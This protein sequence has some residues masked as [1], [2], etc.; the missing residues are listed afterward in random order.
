MA[1]AESR[2]QKGE[3]VNIRR[4]VKVTSNYASGSGSAVQN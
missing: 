3:R 4:T 1:V 2:E